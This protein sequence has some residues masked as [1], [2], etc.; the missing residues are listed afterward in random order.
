MGK[1]SRDKGMRG[2]REF[3]KLV[4]GERVPLSGAAGGRY[5]GDVMMPVGN[6]KEFKVEVKKRASG[7]AMQYRWLDGNDALAMKADHKDWLI[8]MPLETLLNLIEDIDKE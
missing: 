5:T 7:F 4:N 3:K 2:E 6:G 8:C 1:P